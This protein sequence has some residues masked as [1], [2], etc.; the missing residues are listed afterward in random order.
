MSKEREL[1]AHIINFVRPQDWHDEDAHVISVLVDN[2]K[3][4]LAQPEQSKQEP[5]SAKIVE[6][7]LDEYAEYNRVSCDYEHGFEAGVKFAEKQHGIGF[8]DE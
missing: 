2:I 6:N 3:E 7:H 1:L 4:L 8:T 5:L